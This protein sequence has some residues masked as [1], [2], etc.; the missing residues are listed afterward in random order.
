MNTQATPRRNAGP[1]QD[2]AARTPASAEWERR[3]RAVMPIASSRAIAF[4]APY[5]L[6]IVRGEGAFLW[7]ADGHRY[8]DVGCNMFSLVHGNAFPPVMAAVQAQLANG[9]VWPANNQPQIEL[10]ELLVARLPAVESILF[11]NSGTEAFSLA[12]NIARGATGR[13]RFLMARGGYHGTM[14]DPNLAARGEPGPNHFSAP[15]GDAQAFCD[16]IDRHHAEIACVVLEPVQ[17]SSGFT[18]APAGFLRAVYDAC[19]RHGIVFVLDE[20][21]CFRLSAGGYQARLDFRPDLVMLGKIIGGGFPVGAVGGRRD[22]LDVVDPR[23]PRAVASGTF[24]GNPV[25][26]AAGLATVRHL[27]QAA[28]DRIDALAARI[29]TGCLAQAASLGVKLWAR[30]V[31]SMIAFFFFDPGSGTVPATRPDAALIGQ[32]HLALL[33]SGVFAL[34]RAV[35]TPSTVVT[36]AIV[37]DLVARFGRALASCDP[38]LSPAG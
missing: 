38:A 8:I 28:I 3:G 32:L 19:R 18:E 5:P 16:I 23:A 1:E 34:P 2:F 7:D 30:R 27:D 26:M 22:L 20:V 24:S 25:T 36:E 29:V 35:M 10:A 15:F 31:G 21:V 14:W 17:G 13:H 12:L 9:T 11:C 4:H 33:A 6:T 37:D